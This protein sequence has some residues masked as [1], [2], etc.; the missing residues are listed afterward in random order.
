MIVHMARLGMQVC[1][2]AR[3]SRDEAVQDLRR[4]VAEQL[5]LPIE[6]VDLAIALGEGSVH[7]AVVQEPAT[8]GSVEARHS[9]VASDIAEWMEWNRSEWTSVGDMSPRE[10]LRAWLEWQGIVGYELSILAAA[11]ALG[12]VP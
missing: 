5:S 2:V 4:M 9:G 6:E 3:L 8:V 7:Q 1:G 10:A 11:E 12:V